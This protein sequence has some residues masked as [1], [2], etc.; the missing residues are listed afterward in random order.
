MIT[1]IIILNLNYNKIKMYNYQNSF[2]GSPHYKYASIIALVYFAFEIYTFYFRFNKFKCSFNRESFDCI[3]NSIVI[4]SAI[5]CGIQAKTFQPTKTLTFYVKI[6]IF[7]LFYIMNSCININNV[8]NNK[9]Y[10]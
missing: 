4:V 2:F 7:I 8:S 10:S 6:G 3:L 1:I 9:K 5:Y